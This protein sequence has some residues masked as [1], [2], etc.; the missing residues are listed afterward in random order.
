MLS[1]DGICKAFDESA[2]GYGRGEGAGAVVLRRL[3]DAE[4]DFLKGKGP[5]VLAVIKSTVLNQDGKSASF[6]APSG[7]SQQ[8]LLRLAVGKANIQPECLSFLETHGTGTPLGDPIEF[9]AIKSI[10]LD[11]KSDTSLKQPSSDTSPLYLGAVKANIGH[12]EGAAGM[13]GLIK[14][15]M[16]VIHK[17][18]PPNIHFNTKNPA[19]AASAS[20][21]R[22]I[23]PCSVTPLIPE[24]LSMNT[25]SLIAGVS[26]FGSGGTNSHVI[27]QSHSHTTS[28]SFYVEEPQVIAESRSR[29]KSRSDSI[30]KI[31]VTNS[32]KV[33]FLVTGQGSSAD[34]LTKSIGSSLYRTESVFRAMFDKCSSAFEESKR[35]LE[36]WG[37]DEDEDSLSLVDVLLQSKGDTK[38]VNVALYTQC[39]LYALTLSMAKLWQSKGVDPDILLG[40]SL[41]EYTVAAIADIFGIE[42]G[43][44]LVALRADCIAKV[45]KSVSN[46]KEMKGIMVAVRTSARE[47][48]AAIK[49]VLSNEDGKTL[50]PTVSVVNGPSSCVISGHAYLVHKVVKGLD[51]SSKELAVT[52]AFHSPL[53]CNAAQMFKQKAQAF[54]DQGQIIFNLPTKNIVS[55]VTG[56]CV[57]GNDMISLDYWVDHIVKPVLFYD[58]LLTLFGNRKSDKPIFPDISIVAE[59]G[60]GDTLT[61][62]VK[63]VNVGTIIPQQRKIQWVMS[64]SASGVRRSFENKTAELAFFEENCERALLELKIH[65]L[66]RKFKHA[67]WTQT[68]M[69][70]WRHKGK[71]V[72]ASGSAVGTDKCSHS[73]TER[74]ASREAMVQVIKNILTDV[75]LHSVDMDDVDEHTSLVSLGVDS[76]GA[77]QIK[78]QLSREFGDIS[79]MSSLV[80]DYPSISSMCEHISEQLKS[81]HISNEPPNNDPGPVLNADSP[82]KRSYVS[83]NERIETAFE[84][85]R[86]QQAMLFYHLSEPKSC[87]FVETFSLDYRKARS[88]FFSDRSK[89]ISEGLDF[90]CTRNSFFAVNF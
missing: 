6:T 11:S 68:E 49:R 88:C 46:S 76:L 80:F 4:A 59:I 44:L 17:S 45:D 87:S 15:I 42:E 81:S 21:R 34:L 48:S 67:N 52:N 84:T 66:K 7:L 16:C 26:S 50:L 83:K 70:R 71:Y 78:N 75:L 36:I 56:K 20:S 74:I 18:C 85:T 90:N 63:P 53:M 40:H 60:P 82:I 57:A 37:R 32:S 30:D 27:L 19:I 25:N 61:K 77:I 64:F 35:K 31:L 9:N 22:A 79:L 13:A 8:S 33:V 39:M 23:F 10:F 69:H 47:A 54:I 29:T 73:G 28:A 38:I 89:I 62:L 41:G 1:P 12:L 2:D 5:P 51:C 3:K 55:S 43:M 86:M 72:S 58:S 24:N 14:T 65:Q